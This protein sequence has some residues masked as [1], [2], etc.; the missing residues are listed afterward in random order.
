MQFNYVISTN[1]RA[2]K[3]WL[4]YG[5]TIVGT[6]PGAFKHPRHGHVDVFVMHRHL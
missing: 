5:F 6:L 1:Q 4:A 3:T 2:V